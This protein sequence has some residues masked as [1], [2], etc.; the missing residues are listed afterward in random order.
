MKKYISLA[1][2]TMMILS[3]AAITGCASSAP[4][5][6]KFDTQT[7]TRSYAYYEDGREGDVIDAVVCDLTFI[8]ETEYLYT[9]TTVIAHVGAGRQVTNW[10]YSL[11]GTYKT[12]AVDEDEMTKEVTLTAP[13]TGSMVMNGAITTSAEDAEILSYNFPLNVTIN[14]GTNVFTVPEA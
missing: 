12:G 6:A 14:Y 2:I 10:T 7:Y 4:A 9:E 1:L 11:R 3:C 13:T 5:A 8:S